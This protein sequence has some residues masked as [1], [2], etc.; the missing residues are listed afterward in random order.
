MAVSIAEQYEE[1][2]SYDQIMTW[3]CNGALF[4]DILNALT[5]QELSG[6]QAEDLLLK[7]S[8]GETWDQ[9]WLEL[10]ITEE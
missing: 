8:N 9:I 5:T 4:E 7:I 10:G 2:T 1:I 6:A 3:F